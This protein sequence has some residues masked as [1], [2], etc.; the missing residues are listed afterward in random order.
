MLSFELMFS[1]LTPVVFADNINLNSSQETYFEQEIP[2]ISA[3]EFSNGC[4]DDGLYFLMSLQLDL[5]VESV[6]LVLVVII[7]CINVLQQKLLN[8]VR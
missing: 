8:R 5:I 6:L 2:S 7:M 4:L 3:N 1:S